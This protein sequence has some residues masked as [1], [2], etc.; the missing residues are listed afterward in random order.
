MAQSL[1][2]VLLH[3]I[4]STKNREP[5]LRDAKLRADLHAYLAGTLANIKCPAISV[6]GVVNHVH[7]LCRLSR[8]VTVAELV[9]E[10]KTES[11]KCREMMV[12]SPEGVR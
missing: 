4:F 2:N 1:S 12:Q 5:F 3:V 9:E 11:S 7:V 6:G 10:M 8:T